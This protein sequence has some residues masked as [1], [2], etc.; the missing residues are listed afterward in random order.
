MKI[1]RE[2][3]RRAEKSRENQQRGKEEKNA[4]LRVCLVMKQ[5]VGFV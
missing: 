1:N 5:G 4:V 2:K 3:H